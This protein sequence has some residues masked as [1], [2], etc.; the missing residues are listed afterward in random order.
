MKKAARALALTVLL[1]LSLTACRSPVP[2][3]IWPQKDLGPAE[4]YDPSAPRRLLLASRAS[5]F[6]SELARRLVAELRGDNVY[7][8]QI[9]VNQL[10]HAAANQY[11]AIVI[12]ST[13]MA[14]T[15]DPKVAG[16]LEKVR[17]KSRVILVT[18]S[19]GGDWLPEKGPYDA[20]ASAS[21]LDD[22]PRLAAQV[23]EAVRRH[24]P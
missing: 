11:H 19:S 4:H 23:A 15:L 16:F 1:A 17:D 5:D 20:L 2:H 3:M 24:L 7:I 14:R 18:T 9:G 21:R 8:R 6:K 13:T 12:V 10:T 22:T